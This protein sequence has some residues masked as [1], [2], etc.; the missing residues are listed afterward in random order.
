M[1]T[2]IDDSCEIDTRVLS[3]VIEEF[4][5][6]KTPGKDSSA[7]QSWKEKIKEYWEKFLSML[8][9][10]SQRLLDMKLDLDDTL[11]VR[12][13]V[14]LLPALNKLTDKSIRVQAA[15]DIHVGDHIA[16]KLKRSSR[17]NPWWTHMIVTEVDHNVLNV[18]TLC[19]C[20][21][22]PD[23]TLFEAD[24][25]TIPDLLK[26]YHRMD[27]QKPHNLRVWEVS[28]KFSD[29]RKV[30]RYGYDDRDTFQPEEVVERARK[31]I[32]AGA[33]WDFHSKTSKQF[34]ILM[35][36]RESAGATQWSNHETA[37]TFSAVS[38]VTQ[39][40]LKSPTKGVCG[41]C[42]LIKLVAKIVLKFLSLISREGTSVIT[43]TKLISNL[44]KVIKVMGFVGFGIGVIVDLIDFV[45][46]AVLMYRR[47]KNNEITKEKFAKYITQKIAELITNIIFSIAALFVPYVGFLLPIIGLLISKVV[48]WIVGKVWDWAS[49]IYHK[50]IGD[51]DGV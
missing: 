31:E 27:I 11:S 16:V 4:N 41:I 36:L 1:A 26:E 51:M 21:H 37:L 17:I 6:D 25:V 10:I 43:V 13:I 48:G 30:F 3:E 7:V 40:A 20:A 45:Y 50:Q 19:S 23:S 28:L 24:L 12:D 39:A 14:D 8:K 33:L 22:G 5:E 2:D 15:S 18:V 44:N 47:M 32:G 49:G 46:H 29:A 34:A 9:G 42:S 35:K 38:K